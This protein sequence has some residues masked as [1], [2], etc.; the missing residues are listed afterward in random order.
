MV[1]EGG[2]KDGNKTRPRPEFNGEKPI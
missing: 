2:T 1:A